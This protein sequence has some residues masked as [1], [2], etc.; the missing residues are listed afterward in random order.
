MDP[1]AISALVKSRPFWC[2]L[3]FLVLLGAVLGAGVGALWPSAGVALKPCA[4]AFIALIKLSI[5]PLIFLVVASGVAQVGDL[6]KVGRIGLK[7]LVYFEIVST[8]GLLL[9]TLVGNLVD[10]GSAVQRPSATQAASAA[11]YQNSK[12]QSLP[13]FIMGVIPDNV[14]GA[15]VHDNVLQVVIIALLVGA[16]LIKAGNKGASIRNALSQCANLVFG[17]VNIVVLAAPIG[18]FGA[19]GFTIGRFGVHTLYVLGM[20]VMTAWLALA[21][22]VLVVFG[23]ICR[24]SGLRLFDLIRRLKEEA[25]MVITTSSSEVAIPGMIE[26]LE[27]SGVSATAVGLVIPTGYSFNLDGVAITLPMSLLFIAQVYGIHLDFWQQA[28]MLVLMLFISKGAAGVTG[29]AFAAL[30]ATVIASGLPIEGLALLLSVDRFMSQGRSIVNM[31]GNAVA[32]VVVAKWDGEFDAKLWDAGGLNLP[33]SPI[34]DTALA[35]T[36]DGLTPVLSRKSV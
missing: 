9:G 3:W 22:M 34:G 1:K 8:I 35:G 14:F 12:A 7:T 11:A 29:G 17:V 36:P 24:I 32:A 21:F 30:A 19:M 5:P 2:Q 10:L 20:F 31:I 16:A 6:R 26:K 33:P 13:D 18:A 23:L 27:K 28:S 4:D 25:L 15:F